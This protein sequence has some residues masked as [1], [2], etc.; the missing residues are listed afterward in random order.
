MIKNEHLVD[1]PSTSQQFSNIGSRQKKKNS[2]TI[3]NFPYQLKQ[4]K[5]NVIHR[6]QIATNFNRKRTYSDLSSTTSSSDS[7]DEEDDEDEKNFGCEDQDESST[8]DSC[9][10]SS[11]ES[12]SSDSSSDSSECDDDNDEED[13]DTDKSTLKENIFEHEKKIDTRTLPNEKE[14]SADGSSENWGFAAVAKNPVDN[15]YKNNF[16]GTSY[17]KKVS[18]CQLSISAKPNKQLEFKPNDGLKSCTQTEKK[19]IVLLKSMPLESSKDYIKQDDDIPY[20]T[21]E[22]VLKCQMI[23]EVEHFPDQ[24]KGAVN[25]KECNKVDYESE[26]TGKDQSIILSR[27]KSFGMYILLN[28]SV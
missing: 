27:K 2:A 25:S 4:K 20:L 18:N 24:K 28:K 12:D 3:N 6:E 26:V 22:T 17:P 11:S 5:E 19:K 7:E 13:Y 1:N 14:V 9:T 8:S 21:K 10:S 15:K 16:K 23:N